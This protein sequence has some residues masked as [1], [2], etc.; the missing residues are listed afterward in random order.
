MGLRRGGGL[1]RSSVL[2]GAMLA[3][4]P[5]VARDGDAMAPQPLAFSDQSPTVS[6]YGLPRADGYT[7]AEPGAW[8]AGLRV[9]YTSHYTE[10]QAGRESLLFD[11]ETT[12]AALIFER[13]FGDDWQATVEIPFVDHSGGFADGFI[14]DFH[15][16]FGFSDGGRSSAPR[17]QQSFR[18]QRDGRLALDV[19]DSPS[20]VG[21]VRLGLKKR[22]AGVGDWGMAVAGELKLPTGDADRLTGSGAAD[23]S[24]WGTV[25]NNQNG[26]SRWRMLAGAGGLYSGQGDVLEAQRVQEV[27]FGWATLGYAV[28]PSFVVKVQAYAHSAFYEDTDIEALDGTAVAGALGVDWMLNERS[29]MEFAIIEDLNTGASPDVSFLLGLRH[30]F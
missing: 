27:A 21:D 13:G 3:T 5:A 28:A 9:D 11:G 1:L 26:T 10:Q 25:G 15:D 19:S 4:A 30:A 8:R 23:V 12:R 16:V 14:D 20:G 18:Y 29:R 22:L 6:I 17:D 2:V 7:V 24:F